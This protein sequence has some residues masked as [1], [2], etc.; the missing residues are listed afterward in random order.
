LYSTSVTLTPTPPFTF[1]ETLAFLRSFKG[2]GEE[3]ETG[4]NTLTRADIIDGQ[5]LA[6][7]LVETGT[8]EQPRLDYTLYSPQPLNAATHHTALE[9]IRFAFSLDDDLHPFYQVAETDP[10][11]RQMTQQM[12]GYHP[13]KFLTVFEAACWS[14]LKQDYP[15]V[16]TRMRRQ[17]IANYGP[18]IEVEGETYCAFPTPLRLALVDWAEMKAIV[19]VRPRA[20]AMLWLAEAFSRADEGWM[21]NAP[22]DEMY[23]WLRKVKGMGELSVEFTILFGIGRVGRKGLSEA[24]LP[25]LAER[26]N[27]PAIPAAEIQRLGAAYGEWYSYWAQYLWAFSLLIC[28]NPFYGYRPSQP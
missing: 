27:G 8:L 13:V 9:R 6:F 17:L 3:N 23:K 22:D 18:S 14:L 19:H 26:V 4:D 2:M 7:R 11:F 21:R 28:Y 20:D 15:A 10:A 16:S 5:L 12:Y 24:R 25:R 1:A